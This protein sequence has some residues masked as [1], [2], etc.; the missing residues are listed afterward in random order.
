M[1][2]FDETIEKKNKLEEKAIRKHSKKYQREAKKTVRW[3]VKY[4][5]TSAHVKIY[6]DLPSELLKMS[7]IIAV[8]ELND[9]YKGQVKMEVFRYECGTIDGLKAT[10]V[11]V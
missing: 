10:I 3:M 11:Q 8:D 7:Y 2:L 4:G 5:K 6:D 9:Y 1:S